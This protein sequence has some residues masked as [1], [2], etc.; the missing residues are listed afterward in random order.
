MIPT[1]IMVALITREK[2]SAPVESVP[3]RWTA[4]GGDENAPVACATG[5]YG[6]Q[7]S[8]TTATRAKNTTIPIPTRSEIE[9]AADTGEPS[10]GSGSCGCREDAH[11]RTRGSTT[12]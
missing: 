10:A 9:L 5:G 3:N 4:L 1:S 7:I 12:A 6:V 8:E 11:D 2:T